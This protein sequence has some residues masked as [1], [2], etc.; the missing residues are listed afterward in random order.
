MTTTT[1][2]KALS[3][4]LKKTFTY[5]KVSSLLNNIITDNSFFE[6]LTDII[7]KKGAKTIKQNETDL[8]AANV[9]GFNDYNAA[10]ETLEK[11]EGLTLSDIKE[12]VESLEENSSYEN[13]VNLFKVFFEVNKKYFK[14]SALDVVA[15]MEN[16]LEFTDEEGFTYSDD[17]RLFKDELNS[18]FN[19]ELID[20][21]VSS[22]F[23][24]DHCY[25]LSYFLFFENKGQIQINCTIKSDE[26]FSII[27]YIKEDTIEI[28]ECNIKSFSEFCFSEQESFFIEFINELASINFTRNINKNLPLT[29]E[30]RKKL[31]SIL[32]S[33]K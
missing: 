16:S 12:I 7:G 8:I 19:N 5:N 18:Y 31:S 3:K 4:T 23:I 33:Y 27:D 9:F 21:T 15:E 25:E 32:Y 13:D 17:Y 11:K 28:N 1:E 10:I 20:I 2:L 14:Q 29:E 24:G 6:K 30:V 22:C 26:N